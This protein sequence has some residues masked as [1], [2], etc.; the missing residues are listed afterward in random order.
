MAVCV[1][2]GKMG[3]LLNYLFYQNTAK[4]AFFF[5]ARHLLFLSI[6]QGRQGRERSSDESVQR[7]QAISLRSLQSYGLTID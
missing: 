1:K 3:N 4:M 6:L 2:M 5:L 7:T